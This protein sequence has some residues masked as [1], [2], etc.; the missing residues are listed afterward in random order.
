[1]KA[2]IFFFAAAVLL[3]FCC[4]AGDFER[5]LEEAKR[6]PRPVIYNNDGGDAYLFPAN[7]EFSIENFLKLRT[8]ALAGTS[9]S[10]IS[11]CTITSSF[12]QFTHPTRYGEFLDNR[13][14]RPGRRNVTA[15]F[16]ALGT[17]PLR[18]IIRFAR[19][20]QLEVFWANRMNDCHDA[21]HRPDR[22]YER[23]S[24]LKQKHP[25]WLFG[26]IGERL[27]HGVWSAVDFSRPE[28]RALAVDFFR[29]VAERYDI[30]G[31]ELDFFRHFHLFPGVARG[32]TA[33]AEERAGLLDMFRRLRSNLQEIGRRR[34]R[35]ILISIRTPD[36][37]AYCRAAGLDLEAILKERLVDLIIG[38][39]Y[40][41]LNPW[42]DWVELGRRYG[43]ATYASLSESRIRNQHPLLLR[44]QPEVWRGRAAAA[45]KA[46]VDGLHIFNQFNQHSRN[47]DYVRELKDPESFF[48]L[49]KL[50]FVTNLNFDPQRY[51][52]G[53]EQY[54][55]MR[56]LSPQNPA[57][58]DG[59]VEYEIETGES[60]RP[61]EVF[62]ILQYQGNDPDEL[63]LNG[64]A[65]VAV[66]A[67]DGLRIFA[68][69]PAALHFTRNRI[70]LKAAGLRLLDCALA[71]RH[72]GGKDELPE[73]LRL[74]LEK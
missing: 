48:R 31:V 50:Y 64:R 11:Y 45:L 73:K 62:L 10:T 17:D 74:A 51:L 67:V 2:L 46:G 61:K 63:S 68:V 38:S 7:R 66:G 56:L 41:R 27:P 44:N 21:G 34:G 40:F 65:A 12:G 49:N 23:Y 6:R 33:T 69:D 60:V 26:Q 43:V 58:V 70:T 15:D 25:E 54:R 5:Q 4:R 16:V 52:K 35:P 32:G 24:T 8:A 18:E 53:G 20:N 29:E 71:V 37:P 9:V 28:I 42:G 3:P 19:A 36:S 57:A 47:F 30:D 59:T 1:M 22:P 14:Q 39:G 72:D 13:H 55:N